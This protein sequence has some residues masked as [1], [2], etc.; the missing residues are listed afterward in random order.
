MEWPA[1][2]PDPRAHLPRPPNP[3]A[4]GGPGPPGSTGGPPPI[5][6]GVW[7]FLKL[8]DP[9]KPLITCSAKPTRGVRTRG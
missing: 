9:N 3:R 8:Y 2:S 6:L 5:A 1:R 4:L 7:S